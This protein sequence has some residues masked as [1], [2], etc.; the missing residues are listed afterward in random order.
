MGFFGFVFWMVVIWMAIRFWHR[1]EGRRMAGPRG[2]AHSGWYDSGVFYDAKGR[3][4]RSG[5]DNAGDP[6]HHIDALETR[7]SALE[8]RLDFA[9]RLLEERREPVSGSGLP[10]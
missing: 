7:V 8:E 1:R 3:E 9:E 4:I 10:S 2:Y 6:Q 5:R